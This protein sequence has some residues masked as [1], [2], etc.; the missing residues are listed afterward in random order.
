MTTTPLDQTRRLD[1]PPSMTLKEIKRQSERAII[2]TATTIAL[3]S[4]EN[5]QSG[6][7]D[8]NA[9]Y[10]GIWCGDRITRFRRG[11]SRHSRQWLH[12]LPDRLL[13]GNA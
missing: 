4:L 3:K 7:E 10:R 6:L 5:S 13:Q 9:F 8:S 12:V 1:H 2:S 11:L